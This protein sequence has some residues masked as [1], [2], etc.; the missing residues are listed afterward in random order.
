[1]NTAQDCTGL[2][3]PGSV[4]RGFSLNIGN[5]GRSTKSVDG[6]YE[7]P[8]VPPKKRRAE[9]RDWE[10]GASLADHYSIRQARNAE[11][12]GLMAAYP[13][14]KLGSGAAVC[15]AD[16]FMVAQALRR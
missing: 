5:T 6:S 13:C 2:D 12:C 10:S 7:S 8:S 4:R 3:F 16:R 9:F 15:L 1:M 11:S 14:G